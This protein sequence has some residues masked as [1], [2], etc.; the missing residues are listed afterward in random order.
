MT[1]EFTREQQKAIDGIVG[2]LDLS[3]MARDYTHLTDTKVNIA[4]VLAE[5]ESNYPGGIIQF[6]N[7]KKF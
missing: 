1:T 6:Y 3:N 5:L 2:D 4:S 7:E